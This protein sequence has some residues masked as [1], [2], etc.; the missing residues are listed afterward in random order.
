[1]KKYYVCFTALF[2]LAVLV[3]S[4]FVPIK[5]VDALTYD[6]TNPYTSS[7][8]YCAYK[9]SFVY[10]TKYIKN[11]SGTTL[12]YVQLWGSAYCH[13]AWTEVH[14][15]KAAPYDNYADALIHRSNGTESKCYTKGGNG[16]VDQGQHSCHTGQLWDRDPYQSWGNGSIGPYGRNTDWF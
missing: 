3:S 14:L 9:S 15:Y 8:G 7:G 16:S 12:G 13:T 11:S 5:A 6:H 2:A 4:F 10:Q 1:V